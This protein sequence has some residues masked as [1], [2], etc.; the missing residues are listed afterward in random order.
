MPTDISYTLDNRTRGSY[1]ADEACW[2]AFRANAYVLPEDMSFLDSN[3]HSDQLGNS[4]TYQNVEVKYNLGSLSS[5][6]LSN[7]LLRSRA[8]W[9]LFKRPVPEINL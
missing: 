6:I 7:S 8:N 2:I 9:R 5:P 3:W 1:M 4:T